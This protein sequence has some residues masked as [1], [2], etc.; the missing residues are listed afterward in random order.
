MK[1]FAQLIAVLCITA[2]VLADVS[3]IVDQPHEE[4]DPHHFRTTSTPPPPPHPYSFSYTAGR[5]PGHIDRGHT[6]VSDGSGVVRGKFAYVDP[7]NQ[8]RTVEYVA[9]KNGF[10]P[11]LSHE[12]QE[13]EAVKLAT[14]RH[15]NLY[16]KIAESHQD[17]EAVAQAKFRH[18]ELF[19]KIAADHARIG[20]EQQAQRL[21]FE[22]TSEVNQLGF[23]EEYKH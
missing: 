5:F 4:Y 6:E 21:A 14:A 15:F 16:N 10:H 19:G 12:P 22:S 13:T 20:A 3:H 17:S 9:D 8:L 2:T 11:S 1:V 7:R 23:G 18:A